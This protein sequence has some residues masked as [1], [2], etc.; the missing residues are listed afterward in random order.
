MVS[1][2][3]IACKLGFSQAPAQLI[4]KSRPSS[5]AVTPA[6]HASHA[7]ASTYPASSPRPKDHALGGLQA[8]TP[9]A[10]VD[11][12]QWLGWLFH[13]LCPAHLNSHQA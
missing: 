10:P 8:P 2:A 6:A 13:Y 1:V 4:F 11:T 7:Q 12:W 3:R 5:K 9:R